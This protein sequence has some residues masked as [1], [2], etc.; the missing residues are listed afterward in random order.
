M[1][2]HLLSPLSEL[3][4]GEGRCFEVRGRT[5]AVFRTRQGALFATQAACPHRGGPLVD[6][7]LAGETVVCPLHEHRFALGTGRCE[8]EGTD[9]AVYPVR[10]GVDGRIEVEVPG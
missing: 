7:I 8:G 6:G 2:R 3:P 1:T 4:L 5:L 10:V 9:L